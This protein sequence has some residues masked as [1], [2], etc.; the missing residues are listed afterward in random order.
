MFLESKIEGASDA[1]QS[2]DAGD[3]GIGNG[4][5][6][7]KRTITLLG[8]MADVFLVYP[9][10]CRPDGVCSIDTA[11]GTSVSSFGTNPS[12]GGYGCIDPKI[13]FAAAPAAL[14]Q[15]PCDSTTGMIKAPSTDG[16]TDAGPTDAGAD[17]GNS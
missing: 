1:G 15:V 13:S 11:K 6:D 16:G 7:T 8:M 12:N 2:A 9:G 14:Q 3:S 5:V 10:C 4:L 17:G